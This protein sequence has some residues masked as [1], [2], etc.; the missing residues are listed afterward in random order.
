[1]AAPHARPLW[2]I[3]LFAGCGGLSLGLEQAGFTPLLVCEI[4]RDALATYLANRQ[5][6]ADGLACFEDV[7]AI[8]DTRLAEL[9][10]LWRAR[11]IP[12][13]DLIAGGPPCQGYSG[14]GHRR[15]YAV[16]K[17]QIPSNH[18]F[19]EMARIVAR[20]RP[21]MFLFENVKG[22][23]S[24]RWTADGQKGEIWQAV[25]DTFRAI[26]GGEY[27]V[28]FKLVQAKDYGVPQNRPRI[29]MAGI[30]RDLGWTPP[31]DADASGLLPAPSG[32]PPDIE[33]LLSDLIDPRY[34]GKPATDRYPAPPRNALQRRLRASRDG[35][36]VAPKDAPLT[37]QEY[38]RHAPAIREK[39]RHMI[40]HGGEIPPHMRTK[41]F[42]QRVLP[43]VWGPGGPSIT[44]TSLPEDYVH[45][46]QPRTL[47]VR[48]WARLQTFPDW[49]RFCGKRTTGGQRRAGN[50]HA[51]LWSRDVPKYTQIG[52]AVP[53]ELARRVGAHLA[54]ILAETAP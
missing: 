18:L 29:L 51:G 15:S 42:A 7:A 6:L 10:T 46:A 44:V 43:R 1:M 8:T 40:D 25:R 3:D 41:K 2:A 50:P 12:E 34:L 23:L 54:A 32:S 20:L 30:R 53:V 31:A 9:Q 39:F 14:I 35:G 11:G 45:F 5:H 17:A 4:N 48:E 21:R 52:N 16:E 49:Y 28:D 47:T 19:K 37:E 26:N 27:L 13:I 36:A 24:A 38:S 33:A 22:L